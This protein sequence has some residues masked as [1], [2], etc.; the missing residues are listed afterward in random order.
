MLLPDPS[1]FDELP[2][3]KKALWS[4]YGS[5]PDPLFVQLIGVNVE[6]VRRDY[7][8]LSLPFRD[9]LLQAGGAIHGGVISTLLDTVCVPAVGSGFDKARPYSTISMNVQFLSGASQSDLEAVGWVIR[10]G[11]SIAFCSSAVR[12]ADGKLV[13]TAALTF[14]I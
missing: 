11:K 8:R 7:C 2:D 9:D 6:E 10:R 4:R 1:S 5:G 3:D 13:A 12:T 14:K